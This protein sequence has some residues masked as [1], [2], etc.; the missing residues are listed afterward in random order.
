MTLL[1]FTMAGVAFD[2][3]LIT[4][5]IWARK[6]D[7]PALSNVLILVAAIWEVTRA[8][9]WAA[10]HDWFLVVEDLLFAALM[11]WI[12]NRDRKNRRRAAQWLGAKSRALRD[13]LTHT[14]REA[15]HPVN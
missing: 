8:A 14:Q 9:Y 5:L 15:T 3:L 1:E 6:T 2:V 7:R 4:G 12:W 10:H 13:K 11:Y